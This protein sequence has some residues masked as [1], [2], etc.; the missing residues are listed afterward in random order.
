MSAAI[1]AAARALIGVGFRLH[2]RD[3]AQGLD[4]LGLA[5]HAYRAAGFAGRVP[6]GYP[7]RG[8]DPGVIA[9]TIDASGL[10]RSAAP[11]LGDLIL[12]VS[13]PGQLHLAIISEGGVIHAD[14]ALRRVVERP[15]PVPWPVIAAWR[16]PHRGE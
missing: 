9:R 1:V 16:L 6:S 11:A 5:A 3:P 13:G 4:C 7:L 8:G 2:G 14:A 10:V 12:C 15:G